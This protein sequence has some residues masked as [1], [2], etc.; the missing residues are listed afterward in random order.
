MLLF[1]IASSPFLFL[2]SLSLSLLSLSLSLSQPCAGHGW[3]G[4]IIGL[5][6]I[7]AGMAF[8]DAPVAALLADIMDVRGHRD[9]FGSVYAIQDTAISVGF[10]AGP[11][12]GASLQHALEMHTGVPSPGQED[13]DDGGIGFR[14]MSMVFGLLC[15][16]YAPFVCC[17]RKLDGENT[18]QHPQDYNVRRNLS[19][20]GGRSSRGG[21]SSH[22]RSFQYDDD[23]VGESGSGGGSGGG[24]GGGLLMTS[25]GSQ[26][27]GGGSRSVSRDIASPVT[28]R[29]KTTTLPNAAFSYGE[30][31]GGGGR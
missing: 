1:W 27:G 15:L 3:F 6:G 5:I 12:L 10:A 8:I 22:G 19:I 13:V 26:G 31:M 23:F 24:G 16:L 28:P 14:E 2:S 17:L 21:G 11:L 4:L 9:S 20:N 18:E 30:P 29:S 7:G 25:G